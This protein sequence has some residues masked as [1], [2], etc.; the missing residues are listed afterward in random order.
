MIKNLITLSTS[1]FEFDSFS[2]SITT[3]WGYFLFLPPPS[4]LCSP[5]T[6]HVLLHSKSLRKNMA[7]A[8]GGPNNM[9]P[10]S[11]GGGGGKRKS[12]PCG[13]INYEH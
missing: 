9:H 12:S 10:L 4:T 6:D 5:V 11:G 1:A 13:N 7:R 8:S 2:I 3:M